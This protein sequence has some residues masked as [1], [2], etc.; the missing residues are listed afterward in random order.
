MPQDDALCVNV[1]RKIAAHENEP[2]ETLD[3]PL[4]DVIDLE[5]LEQ[6]FQP[7]GPRSAVDAVF[8]F[9]YRDYT[10]TV[11]GSERVTVVERDGTSAT[12]RPRR[13]RTVGSLE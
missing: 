1:A 6:L 3:P 5:V 8:S 11:D 10:V 9:Q 4:Y 12:S 2:V 7:V 13:R